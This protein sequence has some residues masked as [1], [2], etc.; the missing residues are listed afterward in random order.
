MKPFSEACE[1]NQQPILEV[2]K[3]EFATLRHVLEIGSGTG[4]HAIFFG[5]HLPHLVWQTSDLAEHHPGIQAW[6][7]DAGLANVRQ[8][9]LLNVNQS[10]PDVVF[11]GVFSANTAHIMGWKSVVAMFSAIGKR[12]PAHGRFVLYG[13]FNENGRYT[14]DSN[15]NFDRWLKARDP[16]SGLRDVAD[17]TAL[18]QTHGLRLRSRH[19]MP[20]NNQIL[21]WEPGYGNQE[22]DDQ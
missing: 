19:S 15:A 20:A 3:I 7:Q 22:G 13:P 10:W 8:P 4:Q 16:Q 18:A 17:L 5:R 21:V 2:L 1:R 14:S 11:D 9:L 12:L 6:I